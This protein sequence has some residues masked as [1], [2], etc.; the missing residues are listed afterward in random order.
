MKNIELPKEGDLL[1]EEKSLLNR[2]SWWWIIFILAP[3]STSFSLIE[4]LKFPN[5]DNAINF[6]IMLL[7]GGIGLFYIII[8]AWN[9]FKNGFNDE[10]YKGYYFSDKIVFY[11]I[12]KQVDE[13]YTNGLTKDEIIEQIQL[14]EDNAKTVEETFG[15]AFV[16]GDFMKFNREEQIN[17][18]MQR[19]DSEVTIEMANDL[20]DT[21]LNRQILLELYKKGVVIAEEGLGKPHKTVLNF[22][23]V[24]YFLNKK[25][26]IKMVQKDQENENNLNRFDNSLI[27]SQKYKKYPAEVVEFLNQN[28]QK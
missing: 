16:I 5:L 24:K 1:F 28:L 12:S 22:A 26:S 7:I 6:T 23:D 18:I 19:S 27:L 14:L 8:V 9:G 25:G 13:F 15:H 17:F 10:T 4:L 3:I 11:R 21:L 20:C 2:I